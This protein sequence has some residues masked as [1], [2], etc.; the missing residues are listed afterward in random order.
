M[1]NAC[2]IAACTPHSCNNSINKGPWMYTNY[3]DDFYYKV[4]FRMYMYFDSINIVMPIEEVYVGSV[5]API[6]ETHIKPVKVESQILAREHVFTVNIS[7]IDTSIDTYI[8]NNLHRFINS[9]IWSLYKDEMIAKYLKHVK[10][11]YNVILD[12]SSVEYSIQ[13]CWEVDA[14]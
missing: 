7:K 10:D 12:E 3:K 2:L 5:Y 8:K 6:K 11:K 9:T 4:K 13:Y 14:I 1:N